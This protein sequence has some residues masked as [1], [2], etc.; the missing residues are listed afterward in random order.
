MC[1]VSKTTNSPRSP[2]S[3]S[4]QTAVRPGRSGFDGKSAERRNLDRA[5]LHASVPSVNQQGGSAVLLPGGAAAADE[6]DAVVG[7]VH[8]VH[9]LA[10]VYG[11]V[12]VVDRR[13]DGIGQG[14]R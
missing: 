13:S 1:S 12:P 14:S 11:L 8:G 3:R 4:S 10:D 5:D 7:D 6:G 2:S 9:K